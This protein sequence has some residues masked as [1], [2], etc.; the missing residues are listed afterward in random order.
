M[1][2]LPNM[3]QAT[4]MNYYL[5]GLKDNLCPFVTMQQP[6]TVAAAENITEQVDAV[7]FKPNPQTG[8]F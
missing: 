2:E 7:T 5:R 1:L 6:A 4:H 3:D 8:G